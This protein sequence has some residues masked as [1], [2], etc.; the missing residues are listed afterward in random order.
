MTT[1]YRSIMLWLLDG[2][3]YTEISTS[4]GCSRKTISHTK[5]VLTTQD[6]TLDQIQNLTSSQIEELFPDNRRRDPAQFLQPD[7]AAIAKRRMTRTRVT[8]KVEWERYLRFPAPPGVE[9]YSYPQFCSLFDDYV[10]ENDLTAA[11]NHLPGEAMEV[12]W[13]GDTMTVVDPLSGQEHKIQIFVAT[14]PFSGM[15][16][17]SGWFNQRMRNWLYAHQQAFEYFGGVTRIVVPDNASTA[18]NP[19]A[20]TTRVRDLNKQYA[21]FSTH[22]GFGAVAARSYTPKDKPSVEKGVDIAERWIIEYL[23]DRTFFSIDQLNHAIGERVDWINNR[24][25]FRGRDISRREIFEEFEQPEL[26]SLPD[27]HWSWAQWRKSKV[28]MNYHIRVDNHFYSVPWKLAGKTVDTCILDTAIEVIFDNEIV[29]RHRRAPANFQYSTSDE[30]VPPSHKDVGQRWDRDRIL[31][32]A[33]SIGASTFTVIEQMFNARKV[34]AQAYNSA[35]AVLALS[36][37]YSRVELEQACQI[38]V[39]T[40]QVPSTRKVK[41]HLSNLRKHPEALV[42]PS[43]IAAQSPPRRAST[44]PASLPDNSNVRG[45]GA[46]VFKE[47]D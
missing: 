31:S 29:A 33:Q 36:K 39:S 6:L 16:H 3:S 22:F 38:I 27:E 8:R 13:A 41:D 37:D 28:G 43:Q 11:V 15:I 20:K 42:D 7:M 2:R 12:D 35:L 40:K 4:L 17:A 19:V 18:T 24:S 45:A 10:D 9:H 32:W 26:L 46:F 44:R 34:E 30:H 25:E 47:V 23:D 1:D 21:T 14:L 5:H